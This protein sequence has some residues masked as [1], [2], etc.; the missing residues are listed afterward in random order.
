[1]KPPPKVVRNQNAQGKATDL[2]KDTSSVSPKVNS[3]PPAKVA[4][5]SPGTPTNQNQANDKISAVTDGIDRLSVMTETSPHRSS[6]EISKIHVPVAGVTEDDGSHLSNSST[7]P[8]SFDTKSMASENTFALDEKE[9]LRP[10]DS[11]SVQATD[12]DEPFFVPPISGRP[13]NQVALE[14]GSMGMRRPLQDESVP[15]NL[16]VQRLPVTTMANPPRFGE[17][18]PGV[19]QCFPQNVTSNNHLG[20]N[21]LSLES[22]H[23]Y[24]PAPMPLDERLIEAMGTP[25]DRLLL[26]QLEEKFLAFIIQSKY[27]PCRDHVQAPTDVFC[28]DA[29]LDLPPQN[30]Y[31][32]LLTH[33]LADYYTLARNS[34]ADSNSIRLF[35]A[36][37]VRLYDISYPNMTLLTPLPDRRL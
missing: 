33:K 6:N 34:S 14:R 4:P 12:E 7:K 19:L 35:K 24:S 30:S 17:I 3:S 11:A 13:D 16:A 9:S 23:Q 20:A 32:R 26:L 27:G 25:K 29:T 36:V 28:R 8:P 37:E 1:M 21:H 10:D 18:M 5:A 15:V 22:P 31:E 2:Q